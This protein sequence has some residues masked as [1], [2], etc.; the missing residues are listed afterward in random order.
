MPPR[1]LERCYMADGFF[2]DDENVKHMRETARAVG[3]TRLLIDISK[4]RSAMGGKI[5]TVLGRP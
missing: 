5:S 2:D 4:S 1:G 3:L